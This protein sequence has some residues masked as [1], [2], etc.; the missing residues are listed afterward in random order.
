MKDIC[1][2][3]LGTLVGPW[4]AMCPFSSKG[5]CCSTR[6]GGFVPRKPE[7]TMRDS[8]SLDGSR[9]GEGAGSPVC[10]PTPPPQISDAA[11]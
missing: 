1:H 10:D 3:Q 7:S 9:K 11:V 2:R 5:A 8:P 4:L 6:G